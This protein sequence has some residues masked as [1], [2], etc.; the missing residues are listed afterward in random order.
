MLTPVQKEPE[1]RER[2]RR[3]SPG[4]RPDPHS[5]GQRRWALIKQGPA[6]LAPPA[7]R[8]GYMEPLAAHPR[9]GARSPTGAGPLDLGPLNP[10]LPL[11]SCCRYLHR[12]PLFGRVSPPGFPR[13]DLISGL[14]RRGGAVAEWEELPAQEGPP[15]VSVSGL[16]PRQLP[17]QERRGRGETRRQDRGQGEAAVRTRENSGVRC[18]SRECPCPST[19]TTMLASSSLGRERQE[20]G[21]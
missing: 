4:R 15:Q 19:T 12:P 9:P 6:T 8:Q 18:L 7:G 14:G 10:H 21:R 11:T 13:S 16:R 5:P 17:P 2:R 3:L 20:V 1:R